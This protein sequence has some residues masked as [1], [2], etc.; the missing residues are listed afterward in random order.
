MTTAYTPPA[1]FSL[2]LK[3]YGM[4]EN[5]IHV[6]FREH[7]LRFRFSRFLLRTV[8]VRSRGY[9][10]Y[11]DI[12]LD[13]RIMHC[14]QMES[15]R[16]DETT[17]S[18]RAV[19]LAMKHFKQKHGAVGVELARV[20]PFSLDVVSVISGY[21]FELRP[22]RQ[23]ATGINCCFVTTTQ[24]EVVVSD[25]QVMRLYSHDGELVS[26]QVTALHRGLRSVNGNIVMLTGEYAFMDNEAKRCVRPVELG[27]QAASIACR[28]GTDEIYVCE[29]NH[30]RVI[31]LDG[32]TVREVANEDIS[33]RMEPTRCAV[34]KAGVCSIIIRERH[35]W[36]SDENPTYSSV[37]WICTFD[38]SARCLHI[39][40]CYQ[41]ADVA[42]DDS[43]RIFVSSS[44]ELMMYSTSDKQLSSVP[45]CGKRGSIALDSEGRVYVSCP[46]T[47]LL[48]VFVV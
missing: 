46:D 11:C 13:I 15:L 45:C 2:G 12:L 40:Q 18:S 31:Q 17:N 3:M 20:L 25:G 14:F 21:S 24:K 5:R 30:V 44:D 33:F 35:K 32:S 43:G 10:C 1:T 29:P 42:C 22:V 23:I 19:D 36:A 16:S 38:A 48:S 6:Q 9:I 39:H 34:N 27:P 26:R 41:A 7:R 28:E 8:I 47:Q 37:F 4:S